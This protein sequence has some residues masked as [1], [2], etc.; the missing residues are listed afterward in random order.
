MPKIVVKF[1]REGLSQSLETVV[2]H[3]SYKS[4]SSGIVVGRVN[5]VLN[6][7]YV[8]PKLDGE[9]YHL[10]VDGVEG[11]ATLQVRERVVASWRVACNV[12][13][14]ILTFEKV[15]LKFYIVGVIYDGIKLPMVPEILTYL[16]ERMQF[17]NWLYEVC[18]RPMN[19]V[20]VGEGL[21]F[22]D[23]F[24]NQ[25]YYVKSA[26]HRYVDIDRAML[27]KIKKVLS[28]YGLEV[29]PG[30]IGDGIRE[31][32]F[33]IVGKDC[34]FN[35]IGQRQDK[36]YS[37]TIGKCCD[38]I[39]GACA[40]QYLD[41]DSDD[42][43]HE[44]QVTIQRGLLYVRNKPVALGMPSFQPC[45][46]GYDGFI[47][48][49]QMEKD[50]VRSEEFAKQRVKDRLRHYVINDVDN[51]GTYVAVEVN[52]KGYVPRVSE[53][54]F[55]LAPR[56]AVCSGLVAEREPLSPCLEKLGNRSGQ[57]ISVMIDKTL[58]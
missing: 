21:V 42:V 46:R 7:Q 20:G 47:R 29:P 52:A 4:V 41:L 23:A 8:Y 5:T 30:D 22:V 13:E 56:G 31:V 39:L 55:S 1:R 58:K 18:V 3:P 38:I 24:N 35:D 50:I 37:D 9:L 12:R 34:V 44:A 28:E 26:N 45:V 16:G 32:F 6:C 10:L 14:L 27:F 57:S 2:P 49:K 51:G 40:E 11:S 25:Q 54:E 33:T 15:G 48:Y 43:V 53:P 19:G 36:R 17:S